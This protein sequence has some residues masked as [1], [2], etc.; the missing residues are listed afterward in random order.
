MEQVKNQLNIEIRGK[1]ATLTSQNFRLVGGNSD[2]EV[3]FDFDEEWDNYPAKTAMFVFGDHSIKKPFTDNVCEGVE[4]FGATAVA[5]GV[6]AGDIITTKGAFVPV[7]LSIRDMGAP[8]RE[9][10]Q[11]EYDE[12]MDLLNR[13]LNAIK[14]APSGGTKGQVLKKDSDKDYDYSWHDDEMRDLTDY[15]TKKEADDK[16]ATPAIV[17]QKIEEYL[18]AHPPKD[19]FSPTIQITAIDNGHRVTITDIDGAHTFDVM[20]GEKGEQGEQGIQGEK[21]N[22]GYTPKREIDYW[23]ASDIAQIHSYIDEQVKPI[24]AEVNGVDEILA[25]VAEGGAF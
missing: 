19:G 25:S 14:G 24:L 4:I 11:D 12:L 22:D 8:P 1:V 5:I 21:G 3:V 9:P 20:N 6:F 18:T 7:E 15:Y 17:G 13:Y 16:F 23:T 10:T 2:Y